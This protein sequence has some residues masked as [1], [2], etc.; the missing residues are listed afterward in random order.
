[1]VPRGLFHRVLLELTP[2]LRYLGAVPGHRDT[3]VQLLRQG[4]WVAV[5]PGGSEE[6]VAHCTANGREAYK[7]AD[8]ASHSGR[9]QTGFAKE[10]RINPFLELWTLLRLDVLSGYLIRALPVRWLSSLL[11][12]A[13]IF[14]TF[15]AGMLSIPLPVQSIALHN[16]PALF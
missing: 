11:M 5:I 8:W 10:M 1:H 4:A 13:A 6:V 3:A 9:P 12:E 14:V 16:C 7:L 15:W 2:F